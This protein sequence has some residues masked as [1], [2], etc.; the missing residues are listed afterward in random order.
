MQTT[1][2]LDPSGE[3]C[4]QILD[5]IDQGTLPDEAALAG[6]NG[7]GEVIEPVI[8]L[9]RADMDAARRTLATAKQSDPKLRDLYQARPGAP[10]DVPA[11]QPIEEAP[12]GSFRPLPDAL[13]GDP[14]DRRGACP[15]LDDYVRFSE[16]WA[17]RAYHGFH[18]AVGIWVLSTVAARRVMVH[19]GKQR[20]T[21]MYI[22]LI[23][24][25]SVFTK[26][27]AAELGRD[28][29][30]ACGL[31]HLL[32]PKRT[33]PQA[34]IK[35]MAHPGVN[36]GYADMPPEKAEAEQQ[37]IGF[38]ST[39]SWYFE[40]FGGLI[41]PMMR[42]DGPMADFR[43]L[44]REL[45]DCPP[46][47]TADTVSRGADHVD[48]PYLTMLAMMTPDDLRPHAR[49]G[50]ALWGDGFLSRFV[51]LAPPH[52]AQPSGDRFPEGERRFPKELIA[53]LKAWH[54][55]L[56]MP[57]VDIEPATDEKSKHPFTVTITPPHVT[58]CRFGPGVVDA[59]YAY[60]DTLRDFIATSDNTDLDGHYTR[61]AEK[62]LRIAA[63]FASLEGKGLII[64]R[65]HWYK[66]QDIAERWRKA[67][68]DLRDQLADTT[69]SR[70]ADHEETIMRHIVR[71]GSLTARDAGRY[72]HI[73]TKEAFQ[74]LEALVKQGELDAV[75][76]ART[77]RYEPKGGS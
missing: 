11:P 66:A 35:R 34:L 46:Y 16:Q 45:D 33:T 43:G 41:G 17:P 59:F 51:L 14:E 60:A 1:S 48:R 9:A 36:A 72:A 2:T 55:R 20:F 28:L 70:S 71:Q 68:H 32:A 73:S 74:I 57:V 62:A 24:R 6:L 8:E 42:S 30:Y 54:E 31:A 15:W 65:H 37:R 63:L 49:R 13:Q 39:R 23:G 3:Q 47:V 44:L 27:T 38:A 4:L 10:R 58:A 5:L 77:I 12:S 76:T 56:G 75:P 40:E 61:Q 67:L 53:P 29:L 21:P 26:S 69:N 7:W 52:D 18:E 25:S 50:S 64:E 22:S 19:F